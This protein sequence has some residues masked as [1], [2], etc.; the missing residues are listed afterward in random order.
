M[1]L[2]TLIFISIYKILQIE[3]GLYCNPADITPVVGKYV[4][5]LHLTKLYIYN[6]IYQIKRTCQNCHKNFKR[7]FNHRLY[8]EIPW[9][10]L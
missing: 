6:R 3:A 4:S 7:E 8:I 5:I 10:N 9:L 1:I 2:S